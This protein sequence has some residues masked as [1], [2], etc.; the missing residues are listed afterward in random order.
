MSSIVQM[1]RADMAAMTSDRSSLMPR[2]AK[3]FMAIANRFGKT[4]TRYGDSKGE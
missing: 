1:M 3:R 4:F 2:C